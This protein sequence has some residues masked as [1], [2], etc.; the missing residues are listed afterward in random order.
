MIVVVPTE[1]IR[2]EKCTVA[3]MG[4]L[5]DVV[6]DNLLLFRTIADGELRFTTAQSEI[7]FK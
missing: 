7:G 2:G 6:M 5:Q 3:T 4:D 1:D